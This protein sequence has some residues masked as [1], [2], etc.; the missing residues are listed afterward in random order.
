MT[1][2]PMGVEEI[3]KRLTDLKGTLA[4]LWKTGRESVCKEGCEQVDAAIAAVRQLAEDRDKQR[5][6][7]LGAQKLL[8]LLG[9]KDERYSRLL[10]EKLECVKERKQLRESESSLKEA[11]EAER[12]AARE[13]LERQRELVYRAG[14]VPCESLRCPVEVERDALKHEL[15]AL[16][17][18]C[19][20]DAMLSE[21]KSTLAA[22]WKTGRESVMIEGCGQ[23]DA[24]RA[25]FNA[26]TAERDE[27]LKDAEGHWDMVV[28]LRA[29][30]AAERQKVS[31]LECKIKKIMAECDEDSHAWGIAAAD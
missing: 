8:D 3:E 6:L 30:L 4:A 12:D 19:E 20:L 17:T 14:I 10:R 9:P 2:Q 11:L 7:K 27:N 18:P 26:R 15:A 28:Q 13:E 31:R 21:L 29:E 23:V 24:I 16:K 25:A 22:L 1:G 5:E